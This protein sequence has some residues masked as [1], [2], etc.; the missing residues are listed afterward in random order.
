MIVVISNLVKTRPKTK[1]KYNSWIGV[2]TVT[3]INEHNSDESRLKKHALGL[4][5][6]KIK[7]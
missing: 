5:P 1:F 3:A 2:Y 4:N 6:D 7:D